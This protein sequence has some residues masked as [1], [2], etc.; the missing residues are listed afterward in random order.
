[1]IQVGVSDQTL[2]R[3]SAQLG[4]FGPGDPEKLASDYIHKSRVDN[5]IQGDLLMP[6]GRILDHR[7]RTMPGGG[8]VTTFTDITELKQAGD[9]IRALGEEREQARVQLASDAARVATLD[10]VA[11]RSATE[12][13]SSFISNMSHELHTPLTG[14]LGFVELMDRET[15]GPIGNLQYREYVGLIWKSGRHILR[16]INDILDFSKI[17]AGHLEFDIAP[18]D[19]AEVTDDAIEILSNRAHEQGIALACFVAPEVPMELIGDASRIS[20]IVLNLVG[21]AIKFTRDG[22]VR[23]DVS[24]EATIGDEIVLHFETSDTGIGIP[25][26]AQGALFEKFRQA[27]SS[28]TK[29]YGGTGL[30]L[31]ISR[32]LAH[33]MNGDIGLESEVG[34]GSTFWFTVRLAQQE[35]RRIRFPETRTRTGRSAR[36]GG[37]QQSGQMPGLW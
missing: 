25:K 15:H 6:S 20:Q 32:Q 10:A 3:H 33:L 7:R 4:C 9:E 2:I 17:E 36:P 26:E 34:E 18:F 13:K 22:G 21:N 37:R 19:L 35:N 27:D 1:M 16:L 24:R 5:I 23:V 8:W 30:G 11:A 12:A 29:K 28:V 14:M 31:T